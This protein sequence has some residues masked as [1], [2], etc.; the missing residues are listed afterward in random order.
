MVV[1]GVNRTSNLLSTPVP[2]EDFAPESL[3]LHDEITAAQATTLATGAT[4]PLSYRRS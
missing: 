3:R 1:R 2:F 4:Q